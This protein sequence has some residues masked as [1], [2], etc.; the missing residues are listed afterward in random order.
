MSFSLAAIFIDMKKK[1]II[2][3]GQ[4]ERLKF[5]LKE[6]TIHSNIVKQMKEDLDMNYESI[7]N[8]VREGGEYS[9]KPMIMVKA[10]QEVITPKSLYEYLKYKYK[11]GEEFTKQVIRDWMY[12]KITDDYHLSKNTPMN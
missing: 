3:E 6:G 1:L 2:T 7:E 11:M 10:D 12:G 9:E 8:F 4:L 5:N